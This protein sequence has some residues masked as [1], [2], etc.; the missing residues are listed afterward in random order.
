MH[1]NYIYKPGS[2][3]T[4]EGQSRLRKPGR[5]VS[6]SMS[7]SGSRNSALD[8]NRGQTAFFQPDGSKVEDSIDQLGNTRGYNNSWSV[9]ASWAEPVNS[10]LNL[11]FRYHYTEGQGRSDRL[12]HRFNPVSGRYDG[13]DTAYSNVLTTSSRLHASGGELNYV[14]DKVM[15]LVGASVQ[16][17]EQANRSDKVKTRLPQRYTNFFP[18]ANIRYQFS[19]TGTVSVRY[20]GRSS[21]PS[22]DLLQ[23]VP[24]NSNPLYIRLGNPGLKPSF[25]HMVNV[26]I[27]RQQSRSAWSVGID[28]STVQ[29]QV[30]F[31]TWVDSVQY[32]RPVN[33]NGNSRVAY[34][35]N[36]SRHWRG[37]GWSFRM[38]AS[39]YGEYDR[40]V[41]YTNKMQNMVQNYSIAQRLSVG[42]TVKK[43]F[44]ITPSVIVR[45]NHTKYTGAAALP[46]KNTVQYYSLNM[47]WFW[48]KRWVWEND[49]RYFSNSNTAPGFPAGV[50]MWQMAVNYQWGKNER[51]TVRVALYDLLRQTGSISR[52]VT[53]A[54]IEDMRV[55]ALQQYGMVSV[56]YNLTQVGN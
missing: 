50:T 4:P 56:I 20:E 22:L 48:L 46:A 24:D 23:Q 30:V 2:A 29:N 27:D 55:R 33:A 44:S 15:V 38:G 45:Y 54:F 41:A 9:G 36:Y 52:V 25:F 17:L 40:S 21:Q 53:P 47:S 3:E 35:V 43:M 8:G 49:I 14:K 19:P 10:S 12:T 26:N 16:M 42:L 37:K 39:N 5:S 28:A 32:S 31:D 6:L 51:G 18:M 34:N 7:Y 11:L 1:R 13:V